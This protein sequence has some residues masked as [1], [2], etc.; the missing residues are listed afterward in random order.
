MN[1]KRTTGLL[2]LALACGGCEDRPDAPSATTLPRI[3]AHPTTTT[4]V[5]LQDLLYSTPTLNDALPSALG[6]AV[7]AQGCHEMH[8]D[9]WRQFEFVSS[10]FPAEVAAEVAD[11]D[12]IWKEQSVPVGDGLTAFRAIHVRRRIPQPLSIPMSGADLEKL[13]GAKASP[14]TLRGYDRVLDGASAFRLQGVV[15]CS[16]IV[17][18]KL[19]VLGLEAQGRFAIWGELG[20]RLERFL[21]DHDLRLVHWRSRTVFE[22]PQASM[23][24]LRGAAN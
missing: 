11:I 9:D 20:D 17:D 24:Y 3:D 4:A 21:L 7:P 23:T 2:L 8:E 1:V 19:T 12:R 5:D 13:F 10:T 18:G 15:A 6:G 14:M 22:T 16:L